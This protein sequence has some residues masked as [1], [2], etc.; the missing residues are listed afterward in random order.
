MAGLEAEKKRYAAGEQARR[1]LLSTTRTM[2]AAGA[3]RLP[4][5]GV[6]MTGYGELNNIGAPS[7]GVTINGQA[8][9]LVVAPMGG[10]V[11]FAGEF[12]N[13]GR[14]IILEH[15]DDY[16]SLIGGLEAINI[17]VGEKVGA[18]EP[19]GKLPVTPSRDDQPALY[20]ELRYKGSPI[21]PSKKFS[22]L[23]S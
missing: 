23:K 21:D 18:G 22:G 13:Y 6:I 11:R 15:K 17:T 4:V 8:G 16:H 1:G 14:L 2:P 19:V 3:S 20:Y 9:A 5:S 10:I 12:K 7:Q